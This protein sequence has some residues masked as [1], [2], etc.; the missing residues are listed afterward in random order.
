[1]LRLSTVCSAPDAAHG[2]GPAAPGY[3]RV[4]SGPAPTHHQVQ[5]CAT[6]LRQ[7]C[8]AGQSGSWSP[9]AGAQPSLGVAAPVQLL[10]ASHQRPSPRVQGHSSTQRGAAVG[11][12][13]GI[14][15][16]PVTPQPCHHIPRAPQGDGLPDPAPA[17]TSSQ[18][19]ATTE[20]WLP[21]AFSMASRRPSR[22]PAAQ[23]PPQ[24]PEERP[25][26]SHPAA[27]PPRASRDPGSIPLP[28]PQ[29]RGLAPTD[30]PD[31]DKER[32]QPWGRALG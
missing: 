15:T 9:L 27:I 25:A 30:P 23:P 32:G 21:L 11:R 1:M 29:R 5:P 7:G 22:S 31:G 20:G 16:A 12:V 19:A 28:V 13:S 3:R 26:A 17:P 10:A 14:D 4:T 24:L 6:P 18:W 2:P 8:G